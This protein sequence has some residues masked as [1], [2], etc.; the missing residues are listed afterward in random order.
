M[1]KK[2]LIPILA[3]VLVCAGAGAGAAL[4]QSQPSQRGPAAQ[5]RP[6]RAHM[7]PERMAARLKQMCADRYAHAVGGMAYLETRLSL[8][9]DQKPAFDHWKDMVLAQAKTRADKCAAFTPPAPGAKR[10]S[11]TDRLKRQETRLQTRLDNLKA[12]MPA[13]ETLTAKLSTD[14]QRVLDRAVREVVGGRMHQGRHAAF[15][16]RGRGGHDGHGRFMMR[17]GPGGPAGPGNGAPP[18][19]PPEQ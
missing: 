18:P 12:Q 14:Q 17:R 19:P 6:L 8:K 16:H 9:S 1:Q 4:A 3:S 13:L 10:P 5:T 2:V 11:L 7:N 15:R